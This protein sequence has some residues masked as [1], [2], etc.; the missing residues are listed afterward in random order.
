MLSVAFLGRVLSWREWGGIFGVIGGLAIVG[1]SDFI[2]K[3]TDEG[4]HNIN[5]VITGDELILIAQVIIGKLSFKHL[6]SWP[7]LFEKI[8]SDLSKP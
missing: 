4:G 6:E 8:F 5:D 2:Y 1:A 7:G 3:S